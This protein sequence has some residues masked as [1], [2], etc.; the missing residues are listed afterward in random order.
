M[1]EDHLRLMLQR[2]QQQKSVLENNSVRQQSSET[3]GESAKKKRRISVC[4]SSTIIDISDQ[5]DFS[6]VIDISDQPNSPV[7]VELDPPT[8]STIVEGTT[9]NKL[10]TSTTSNI[11]SGG[12]VGGDKKQGDITVI[13]LEAA[14]KLVQDVKFWAESKVITSTVKE[15]RYG[16][17]LI[18][19][20]AK[21]Q[22]SRSSCILCKV[23]NNTIRVKNFCRYPKN[24]KSNNV[25]EHRDYFQNK[26]KAY[27]KHHNIGVESVSLD[28][29][30]PLVNNQAK[31]RQL[32]VTLIFSDIW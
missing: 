17:S 8:P 27:C 16:W 31:G 12:G 30:N 4:D 11:N 29:C 20:T 21:F 32:A 7:P 26:V 19:V 24:V 6:A 1:L 13:L 14:A 28:W 3:T 5:S 25:Y 15:F 18:D 10:A 9:N 22:A 2:V 23:S